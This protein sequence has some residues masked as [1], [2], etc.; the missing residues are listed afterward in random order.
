MGP[1]SRKEGNHKLGFAKEDQGPWNGNL[2]K[3]K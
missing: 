1:S 3:S 2:G